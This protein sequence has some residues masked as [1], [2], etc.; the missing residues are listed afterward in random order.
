MML[1][2]GMCPRM[3]DTRTVL[4]LLNRYR[5]FPRGPRAGSA[6]R[7]HAPAGCTLRLHQWHSRQCLELIRFCCSAASPPGSAPMMDTD[8][9]GPSRPRW[10]ASG[11]RLCGVSAPA[12]C[13]PLHCVSTRRWQ[14]SDVAGIRCCRRSS[15]RARESMSCEYVACPVGPTLVDH[16]LAEGV[17]ARSRRPN[18]SVRSYGRPWSTTVFGTSLIS[19]W[20]LVREPSVGGDLGRPRIFGAA[21]DRTAQ[22]PHPSPL[23]GEEWGGRAYCIA[24]SEFWL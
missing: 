3:L 19:V 14:V 4:F 2:A 21:G 8:P 22:P 10:Q 9:K 1:P 16:A 6:D 5:R 11:S 23:A 12:A 18:P 17:H 7:A 24:P 20:G 13:H 15:H